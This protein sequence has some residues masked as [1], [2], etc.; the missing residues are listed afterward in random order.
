MLLKLSDL[1]LNVEVSESKCAAPR[2]IF[3]I[4]GFTGSACDWD[5]II[6][7]I[8][9][10]YQCVAVDLIGHGKSDSPNETSY[11]NFSSISKQLKFL[12][13]QF[14]N[15][16][17]TLVGYSMGGRVA[18]NFAIENPG[19]INSLI[20]ES[21][22]A[23]IEDEKLRI[24]RQIQDEKLAS[25]IIDNSIEDFVDYWM[26]IDLF[27]SQKNLSKEK[28][29]KIRTQKSE[30]NKTGLSN[31]LLGFGAGRMLPLFDKL[32]EFKSKTLLIT[33]D[34]DKKYCELNSRMVNIF[35]ASEHIIIKNAGH[36]CHLEQPGKFIEAINSFLSEF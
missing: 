4:H 5:E 35:P 22:S 23:G 30:N 14:T 8:N 21:S 27:A 7:S 26:N 2:Y 16:P 11:Y 17:V 20:L 10:N 36:N 12:I 29:D 28:L 34:Q 31:S 6:P 25:Y 9:N 33:G 19:Q 13:Y 24:E 32:K 1:S 18:L 3:F 15:E